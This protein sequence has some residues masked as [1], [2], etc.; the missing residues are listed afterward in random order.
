MQM[1][2]LQGGLTFQKGLGAVHSMSHPLGGLQSPVLHHGTL[3][4]VIL[5]AV[6]RFNAGHVGDKY[7]RLKSAMKVG[8]GE[9]LDLTIAAFNRR[10]GLP[11]GLGAM[12]VP[13]AVVPAMVKGALADHSTATNPRPL[14]AED[15]E[16]LFS[17]A[18]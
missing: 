17:E 14:Q 18:W 15:F 2:S 1:A 9:Q 3:N 5:P 10:I 8:T 16:R 13:K 6:L 11:T 4:A 7:D 12:G